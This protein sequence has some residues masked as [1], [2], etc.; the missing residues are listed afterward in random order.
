MGTLAALE[1][2]LDAM[3][4]KCALF[5]AWLNILEALPDLAAHRC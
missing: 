1:M 2:G 5:N 3:R 4:E